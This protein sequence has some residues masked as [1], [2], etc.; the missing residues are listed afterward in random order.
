MYRKQRPSSCECNTKLNMSLKIGNIYNGSQ[1]QHPFVCANKHFFHTHSFLHAFVRNFRWDVFYQRRK[2]KEAC[3][4]VMS[5]F[6]KATTIYSRKRLCVNVHKQ[7]T[8]LIYS[9]LHWLVS[10]CV[11]NNGIILHQNQKLSQVFVCKQKALHIA[12][13][14]CIL[15]WFYINS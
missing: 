6:A 10:A 1:R 13:H 11:H 2:S 4:C 3:M 15:L 8:E 9:H 14:F 5:K 12:R 7:Q